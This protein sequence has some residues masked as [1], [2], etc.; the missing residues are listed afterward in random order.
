SRRRHRH[1]VTLPSSSHVEH[2]DVL[3]MKVDFPVGGGEAASVHQ[4]VRDVL[5]RVL[6][7]GPRVC[8]AR[9]DFLERRIQISFGSQLVS[10]SRSDSSLLHSSAYS[11]PDDRI[12]GEQLVCL[13]FGYL[14]AER[15]PDL[16]RFLFSA[17]LQ[18]RST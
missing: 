4:F 3:A 10:V 9:V 8:V 14:A 18:S 7:S 17:T 13:L 5:E 6:L 11:R 15:H 12:V 1:L 2:V 16:R